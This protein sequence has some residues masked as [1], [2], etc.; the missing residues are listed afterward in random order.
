MAKMTVDM[1][2]GV[3]TLVDIAKNDYRNFMGNG[4][5]DVRMHMIAEYEGNIRYQVGSKYIKVIQRNSVHSFIV[6]TDKDKKF[7]KGDILK[8]A[9]WAAP[10]RNFARGNVLDGDFSN[11]RWTG[12]L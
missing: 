12:A 9:G 4:N 10:A 2:A 5:T 1:V 11:I 3:E 8:P 6:N 7:R